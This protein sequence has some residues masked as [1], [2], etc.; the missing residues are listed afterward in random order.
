MN[1]TLTALATVILVTI[2]PGMA[3]A[4][5]GVAAGDQGWV[6]LG[7]GLAIGVAALGGGFGQDKAASAVLEGIARNPQAS[8]KIFTP[9]IIGL[10]LIES[11]VVYVLLVGYLLYTRLP[12][13]ADRLTTTRQRRP[14]GLPLLCSN[15]CS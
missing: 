5:D 10:T 11:L 9:M 12:P 6:G 15:T 2:I 8:G 1:R 3:L 13:S 14:S 7:A 4:A